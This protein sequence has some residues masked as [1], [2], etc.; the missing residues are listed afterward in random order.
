MRLRRPTRL[1]ETGRPSGPSLPAERQLRLRLTSP[2]VLIANRN[3][4]L[5]RDRPSFANATAGKRARRAL[6]W[7]IRL[8]G[9]SRQRET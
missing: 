5:E 9:P 7:I 8:R 3:T 2:H 6:E 4:E 1:P